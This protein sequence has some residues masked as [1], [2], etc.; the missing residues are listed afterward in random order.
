MHQMTE[1]ERAER[2]AQKRLHLR[3]R[4]ML[5]DACAA[6]GDDHRYALLAWAFMRG[7]NYRRIERRRR[8]QT[9]GGRLADVFSAPVA[10]RP[11]ARPLEHNEPHPLRVDWILRRVRG[12]PAS[13]F[14]YSTSEASAAFETIKSWISEPC[15]DLGVLLA[16]DAAKGT[17]EPPAAAE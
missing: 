11:G 16:A 17:L 12:E 5:A 14:W 3:C 10:G 4:I 13:A 15:P 9:N 6:G 7:L 1:T 8:F 2:E